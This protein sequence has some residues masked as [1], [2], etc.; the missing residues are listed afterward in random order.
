M[1]D[2]N[3]ESSLGFRLNGESLEPL[4]RVDIPPLETILFVDEQKNE[5]IRNTHQFVKYKIAND[6][7]LW[8][9]RGTGKSSLVK[10]MLNMFK[11]D[12]RII[13]MFKSDI[14]ILSKLYDILYDQPYSFI[15]FFDDLYFDEN[16]DELRVLKAMLDGSFEERPQNVIVYATSNRRFMQ[17]LE[18]K[19]EK[20]EREALSDK[21]SLVERFGLRLSFYP[22]NQNTYLSIV[23]QKLKSFNIDF[24]EKVK[25]E[26]LSF[27]NRNSSFSG[28]TAKQ[29]VIY[30]FGKLKIPL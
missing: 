9:E 24:D 17:N 25:E 21:F 3:F 22:F 19:Q 18:D 23:E 8:G 10:A 2:T 12:L 6:V 11:G 26:A 1:K 15:L 30:Y 7:L 4:K 20:F 13:Q 14:K 5:L 29:F 27:A 16:S 28:R